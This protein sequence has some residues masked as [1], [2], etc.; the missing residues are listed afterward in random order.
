LAERGV[1]FKEVDVSKDRA[2]AEELQRI[3]GQLAVPVIKV[4]DEVIVGFNQER[5][6][7]LVGAGS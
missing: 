1:P 6:D 5:L 3:S 4:D 2:S 7:Q